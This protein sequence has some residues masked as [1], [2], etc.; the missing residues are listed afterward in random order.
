MAGGKIVS[1]PISPQLVVGLGWGEIVTESPVGA[2]I[3]K[4]LLLQLTW[5]AALKWCADEG[6]QLVEI[7]SAAKQEII[8]GWIRRTCSGK[9]C[10][11]WYWV[12]LSRNG[13]DG[14]WRWATSGVEAV[15][16]NWYVGE[17]NNRNMSLVDKNWQDE[18]CV[19][20][21]YQFVKQKWNDL[22][23]NRRTQ[24]ICEKI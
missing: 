7:G 10:H 22:N 15:Y 8:N 3:V 16:D 5:S 17:P 24:A 2:Y 11:A 4:T 14:K 6:G 13:T 9:D 1:G 21:N 12:G 20:C 18:K 19:T 23:C